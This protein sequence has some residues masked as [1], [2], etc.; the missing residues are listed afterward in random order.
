M[1]S[2]MIKFVVRSLTAP[3]AQ[4]MIRLNSPEDT[5]PMTAKKPG[6][7]VYKR[8]FGTMNALIDRGFVQSEL[9][10]EH[11]YFVSPRDGVDISFVVYLIRLDSLHLCD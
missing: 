6:M 10:D 2:K 9:I 3:M 1:N 7:I 8:E 11:A 5:S 4:M